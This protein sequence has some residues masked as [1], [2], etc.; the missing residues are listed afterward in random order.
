MIMVLVDLRYYALICVLFPPRCVKIL[1]IVDRSAY[2]H[3]LEFNDGLISCVVNRELQSNLS[4]NKV[5]NFN[6]WH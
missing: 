4:Y 2:Q 3:L 1:V 6:S 5:I